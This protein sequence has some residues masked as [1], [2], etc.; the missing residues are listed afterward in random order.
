MNELYRMARAFHRK[1]LSVV[2]SCPW[3]KVVFAEELAIIWSVL[4]TS[5][6]CTDKSFVLV[7]C[8]NCK[9]KSIEYIWRGGG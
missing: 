5:V 2:L 8:Y 6:N 7:L 4:T 3:I 9:G 1:V